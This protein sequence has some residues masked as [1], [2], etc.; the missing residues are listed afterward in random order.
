MKVITALVTPF[1]EDLS[2]DYNAL[3]N[4]LKFQEKSSV[5]GLLILGT[6][7]ESFS[8]TLKEKLTICKLCFS[9]FTR[10]KIIGIEGNTQA[11]IINEIDIF[12]SFKPDYFLIT[13]PYFIKG[14]Q[15]GIINYYITIANYSPRP[16]FIYNI[17]SRSG[18]NIDTKI[19]EKIF[20]HKNIAGIK[21]ASFDILYNNKLSLFNNK[22][23]CVLSGNDETLLENLSLNNNG[24]FSVISNIIPNYLSSIVNDYKTNPI[25]VSN[26]YK[27]LN[28]VLEYLQKDVNPLPIKSLMYELGIIKKHLREPFSND[29]YLRFECLKERN[30]LNEYFTNW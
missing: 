25:K 24:V 1:N 14:D 21:N 18:L 30:I 3:I 23:F 8:L 9:N 16:I 26:M 13:P 28:P 29:A 2:V 10:T 5:D 27:K 7:S 22:D 19:I 6:T 17:P 4:L 11:K 20:K 15:K 12:K